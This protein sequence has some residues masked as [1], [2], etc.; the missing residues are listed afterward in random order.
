MPPLNFVGSA[1]MDENRSYDKEWR[2]VVS[3]RLEEQGKALQ[4]LRVAIALLTQSNADRTQALKELSQDVYELQ[5]FQA[6]AN[7]ARGML[8]AVGG[9][10][11]AVIAWGLELLKR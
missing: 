6:S 8:I 9:V 10:I 3:G 2:V 7:G 5:K 11:G 4:E 1:V